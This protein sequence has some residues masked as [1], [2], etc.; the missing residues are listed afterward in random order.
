MDSCRDS[1]PKPS[2]WWQLWSLYFWSQKSGMSLMSAQA[3][4]W[5]LGHLGLKRM[6]EVH[7]QA[8]MYTCTDACVHTQSPQPLNEGKDH[9]WY[10]ITLESKTQ[11]GSRSEE[12]RTSLFKFVF[13]SLYLLSVLNFERTEIFA[14]VAKVCNG[15]FPWMSEEWGT[16][17]HCLVTPS[18]PCHRQC[19]SGLLSWL[20]RLETVP[21][22][23]LSWSLQWPLKTIYKLLTVLL[24]VYSLGVWASDAGHASL[25]GISEK[26][27][28]SMGW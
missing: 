18:P 20:W 9:H 23:S 28:Y 22:F 4:Q 7:N 14:R 2:Q 26:C 25:W 11:L 1:P 6:S 12:M 16:R 10:S 13:V 3:T 5:V 27:L 19:R 17:S 8:C 21:I 24:G 15:L